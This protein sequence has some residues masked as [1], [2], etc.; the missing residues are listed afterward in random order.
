MNSNIP[1]PLM[2]PRISISFPAAVAAATAAAAAAAAASTAGK[3]TADIIVME[4]DSE[5]SGSESPL[6]Q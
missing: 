4:D 1:S 5:M 3:T 6:K 2:H